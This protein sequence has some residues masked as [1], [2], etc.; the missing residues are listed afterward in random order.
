MV[1]FGTPLTRM[2]WATRPWSVAF[3]GLVT[4]ETLNSGI[5]LH[6]VAF[7]IVCTGL[8][9]GFHPHPHLLPSREKGPDRFRGN[10]GG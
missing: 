2:R 10:D 7:L 8:G 3:V 5:R 9:L 1:S 6:F 4:T